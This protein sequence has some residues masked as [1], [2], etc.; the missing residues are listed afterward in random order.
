[1]FTA[2]Q[3]I[4]FSIVE[5][6]SHYAVTHVWAGLVVY[7]CAETLIIV[8]F[9]V[10]YVLWRREE[11]IGHKHGNQKAVVMAI[12][13]IF[14]ALAIKSLVSFILFRDRPFVTHPEMG[15]LPIRV[16][17]ASFPSGHTLLT[18]SLAASL[19]F[20]GLKKAGWLLLL[21]AAIIGT[22]RIAAGVHYP[23]D[24]IGGAVIGIAAAWYIHREASSLKRYL[25]NQ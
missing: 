11:P 10:M 5:T 15:H 12:V 3:Q 16:D 4:D 25:P 24:V 23:T 7:F 14:L 13:S 1:M 8:P 21:L 18:F 17:S 22:A 6:F 20:S 9:I 2:L 19:L